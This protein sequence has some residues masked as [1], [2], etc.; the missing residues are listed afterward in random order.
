MSAIIQDSFKT[1]TLA[2]FIASVGTNHLYLGIG[3]PEYWNYGSSTD[4]VPIPINSLDTYNQDWDDM[5]QMKQ[6]LSTDVSAGVYNETWQANVIYDIYRNNWGSGIVGVY[7]GPNKSG[8]SQNPMSLSDVKC[9]VMTSTYNIY[10][11]VKQSIVNGVV[12]PSIYS[13]DTGVAVLTND[14][15]GVPLNTNTGVYA[16]AD[17]YYW[18]F[19]ANTSAANIIKFS[20]KYYT[21][22]QT[23]TVAPI[24]ADAYYSQWLNQVVSSAYFSGG[25]YT[26]N[27]TSPGSGYNGGLAG[28]H[29]VTNAATD[30]SLAVIGNGTNLIYTV[31]YGSGGTISDIHI[32]NPG[33][34]YT[35]ASIV[36]A[37]GGVGAVFDIIYTP[38]GGLGADPVNNIDARYLLA[39]TTL[40]G[41]E[42]G[43]FTT[44]NSFRKIN[45]VYNPFSYGTT[46]VAT[47]LYLDSTITLQM[48]TGLSTGAYPTNAVVTG[49]TSLAKGLVVDFN[50]TTGALRVIRT[51][52]ENTGSQGANKSFLNG[53]T[54]TCSPGT[55][56]AVI[57][58]IPT[59]PQVAKYTGNILYSEYRAPILRGPSQTESLSVVVMF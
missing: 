4:V 3:R 20:S 36:T 2:N 21:P 55:G 50:S 24:P 33:T 32:T 41:A 38:I 8:S 39:A 11:C 34:G 53:E 51:L 30:T 1:N 45:L 31:T 43:I 6:L 35:F 25:I 22:I 56:A 5:L 19:I 7:N 48:G 37:A 59:P 29:T 42:G 16:T 52:N 27:V 18:K 40:T 28:T 54:L 58:A 47:S 10:M 26:I 12:Q 13:P 15:T 57:T 49:V 9:Y 23:L 44:S 46:N 17:G 14:A